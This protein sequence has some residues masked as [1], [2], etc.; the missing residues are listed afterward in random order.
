MQSS[1]RQ[2]PGITF[3]ARKLRMKS[4][5]MVCTT[6]WKTPNI[7]FIWNWILHTFFFLATLI[8][9][10]QNF[11]GLFQ[12]KTLRIGLHFSPARDAPTPSGDLSW[13]QNSHSC[14]PGLTTPVSEFTGGNGQSIYRERRCHRTMY[15]PK[16][17]FLHCFRNGCPS[18]KPDNRQG[19]SKIHVSPAPKTGRSRS[20]CYSPRQGCSKRSQTYCIA[21]G[22]PINA[23]HR[24]TP[25]VICCG[26]GEE[27]AW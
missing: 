5:S 1:F 10:A 14:L 11:A 20:T 3:V 17:I 16:A 13:G 23:A 8:N 6:L 26:G 19:S 7:L 18:V 22:H 27:K 9:Y 21:R 24:V 12:S 4:T 25:H 2:Q 15:L